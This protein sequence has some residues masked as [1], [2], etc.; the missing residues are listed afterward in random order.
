MLWHQNHIFE[1]IKGHFGRT[2][3]G[4]AVFRNGGVMGDGDIIATGGE[5]GV[6]KIY[7]VP[8]VVSDENSKSN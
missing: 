5:D 4:L 6:I 1:T 8:S 3:R 7:R 2:T